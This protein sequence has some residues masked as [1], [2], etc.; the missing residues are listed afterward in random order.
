MAWDRFRRT[1]RTNVQTEFITGMPTMFAVPKYSEALNALREKRGIPASFS[2]N[3]VSIDVD[4]HVASF[5][6]SEGSIVEKEYSTLHVVPPMGPLDFIKN[7]PIADGVGWVDVDQSTMQHKKFKNVYALGDASSLPTSKTAAAITAQAPVLVN[8][9]SKYLTTGEGG[10]AAY[11]GYTSCPVS[12][13]IYVGSS[14]LMLY[15]FPIPAADW[16]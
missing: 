13:N 6:N 11:D 9:V 4:K 12:Y 16:L 14:L 1:G 2:H 7:S 3:L 8:N 15:S 5:K 10:S